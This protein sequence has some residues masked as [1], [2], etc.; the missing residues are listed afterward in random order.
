MT[1]QSANTKQTLFVRDVFW[2]KPTVDSPLPGKMRFKIKLAISDRNSIIQNNFNFYYK[3]FMRKPS[4]D[5]LLIQKGEHNGR[6]AQRKING[7]KKFARITEVRNLCADK[8][9]ALV[10]QNT[11]SLLYLLSIHI[12]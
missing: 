9:W 10:D 12:K 2:D 1:L 3:F 5:Q 8:L 11:V 4:K 6:N 7:Q